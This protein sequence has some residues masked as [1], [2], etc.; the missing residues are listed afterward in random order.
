[1]SWPKCLFVTRME[2]LTKPAHYQD[3]YSAV[4]KIP[5]YRIPNSMIWT[6]LVQFISSQPFSQFS[7]PPPMSWFSKWYVMMMRHSTVLEAF[8][9][10]RGIPVLHQ[11]PMS[12]LMMYRIYNLM[13]DLLALY[14][15]YGQ[16]IKLLLFGASRFLVFVPS[17]SKF[18]L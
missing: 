2:L 15:I 8:Q 3:C 9:C 13:T 14:I 10:S 12:L 5:S 18:L 1:M 4:T 16:F 7:Y 6:F 17:Q 11:S